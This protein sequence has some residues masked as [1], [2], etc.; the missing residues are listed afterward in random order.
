MPNTNNTTSGYLKKQ[1]DIKK[2]SQLFVYLFLLSVVLT[3]LFPLVLI[4]S[5]SLKTQAEIYQNYSLI[6]SGFHYEN[7]LKLFTKRK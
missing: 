4:I 3:V 2:F 7:Y 6:P 1:N 5:T